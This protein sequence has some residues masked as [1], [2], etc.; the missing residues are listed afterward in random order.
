MKSIFKVAAGVFALSLAQQASA[1]TTLVITG[2]TAFRGGV[3]DTIVAVMGGTPG[4]DTATCKITTTAAAPGT[5]TNTTA[6]TAINAANI[7]TFVGTFPGISGITTIKCSMS[8]SATGL[9]AIYS[10]IP[11]SIVDGTAATAGYSNAAFGTIVNPTPVAPNFAFSD[12]FQSSVTSTAVTGLSETNVAVVPFSFVANK[13]TATLAPAFTNMTAQNARALYSSGYE[14]VWIFTGDR[15]DTTTRVFATGRDNGSGTRITVLAETK[16]GVANLVKHYVVT[17]TGSV[18]S[19]TVTSTRLWPT[20]GVATFDPDN[21]GNGGYGSG[22]S[23]ATIM[24]FT[25]S[26]GIT[27]FR[28]N[29]TTVVTDA[30]GGGTLNN[31][32]AV[33]VG[34]LGES[35]SAAAVTNGGVRLSYE[36][37]LFDGTAT[38]KQNV[39]NGKY[40]MWCYEHLSHNGAI[41]PGSAEE[42]F[43]NAIVNNI[44]P[45]LGVNGL[46]QTLM[47]VARADDGA[48]VGP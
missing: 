31:V 5:L 26:A 41:T 48:V 33:I 14:P 6:H 39:Y 9:I 4:S 35:D 11:Q 19:G 46:D 25:S 3:Y 38:G 36:G 42:T 29:G 13:G 24:G 8:G 10:N 1:D 34:Y 12:V 43:S 7:V 2:S 16:Y 32:P 21:A 27:A 22:G 44:T 18:G 37:S 30:F 20:S 15:T 40:T 17:T 28:N 47:K 45:N 23:I